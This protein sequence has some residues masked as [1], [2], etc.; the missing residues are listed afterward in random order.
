M[1]RTEENSKSSINAVRRSS[2]HT[3]RVHPRELLAAHLESPE[4]AVPTFPPTFSYSSIYAQFK[5]HFHNQHFLFLCY[6][7]IFIG[8][9]RLSMTPLCDT[10]HAC[11]TRRQ[12]GSLSCV[13]DLQ[14]RCVLSLTHPLADLHPEELVANS[15]LHCSTNAS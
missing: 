10:S 4:W 13:C 11:L 6:T 3:A 5:F 15:V 9:F 12:G 7:F 8:H 2:H 14:S 1:Q